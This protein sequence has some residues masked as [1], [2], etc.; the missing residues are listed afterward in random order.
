MNVITLMIYG[1][2]DFL[3]I[4]GWDHS[5]GFFIYV[6]E[7][8]ECGDVGISELQSSQFLGVRCRNCFLLLIPATDQY[9]INY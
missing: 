3:N 9:I 6:L 1:Y 4:I 8:H 5:V 7:Y 2:Q